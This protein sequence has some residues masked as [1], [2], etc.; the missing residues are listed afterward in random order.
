MATSFGYLHVK[1]IEICLAPELKT[2]I[3]LTN[4]N[5]NHRA[6]MLMPNGFSNPMSM[7]AINIIML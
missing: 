2:K 5:A 7:P 3:K 6:S 1:V 4:G